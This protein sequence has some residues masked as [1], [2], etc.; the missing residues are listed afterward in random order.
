MNTE[1]Q[2]P[3]LTPEGASEFI[4]QFRTQKPSQ[5]KWL[6]IALGIVAGV[7]V[8]LMYRSGYKDDEGFSQ[9]GLSVSDKD[10]RR[11]VDGYYKPKEDEDTRTSGYD[12]VCKMQRRNTITP[13]TGNW[14][15]HQG[16]L[17]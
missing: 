9:S 11:L 14:L 7:V 4:N 3:I 16:Y 15:T 2:S 5:N 13:D 10:C 1:T 6:L 8:Y 12:K 17:M